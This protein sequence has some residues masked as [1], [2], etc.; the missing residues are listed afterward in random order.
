[1][2]SPCLTAGLFFVA[3]ESAHVILIGKAISNTKQFCHLALSFD[4][5]QGK[6]IKVVDGRNTGAVERPELSV[7]ERGEGAIYGLSSDKLVS[8]MVSCILPL[9]KYRVKYTQAN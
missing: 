8:T 9:A 4:N 3:M 1:M 7:V 6:D 2:D 5:S